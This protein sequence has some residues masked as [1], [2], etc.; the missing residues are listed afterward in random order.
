MVLPTQSRP[1]LYEALSQV[2]IADVAIAY[3]GSSREQAVGA[4][5]EQAHGLTQFFAAAL[6]DTDKL[7]GTPGGDSILD[8]LRSQLKANAMEA[9][10]TLVGLAAALIEEDR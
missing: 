7:L 5:L 8:S 2:R 9:I 3:S 6:Q 1:S 10:G 4:L